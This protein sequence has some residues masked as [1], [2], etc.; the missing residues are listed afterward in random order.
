MRL[1]EKRVAEGDAGL[2][3]QPAIYFAAAAA[4][5]ASNFGDMS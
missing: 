5:G 3:E 4:G 2:F 1:G